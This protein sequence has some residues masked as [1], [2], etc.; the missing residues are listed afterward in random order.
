MFTEGVLFDGKQAYSWL[1]NSLNTETQPVSI[2]SAYLKT[3][4]AVSLVEST[5]N[6]QLRFLARWTLSDLLSGASDLDTYS[7]LR[8]KGM[9]LYVCNSFHGKVYAL[10]SHSILVGSANATRSGFGLIDQANSEVCTLVNS[11]PHNLVLVDSLFASAQLVTDELFEAMSEY[12]ASV[13]KDPKGVQLFWPADIANLLIPKS[14]LSGF[15]LSDCLMTDGEELLFKRS[16]L[17][18]D[19]KNDLSLLSCESS[20]LDSQILA[21]QFKKLKLYQWLIKTLV[22]NDGEMYFGSLTVALHDS[23]MEDPSPYRKTVKVILSN[24][25]NWINLLG[26]ADTCIAI[27]RPNHSQRVRLLNKPTI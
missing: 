10:P 23:M 25:L 12:V 2:C 17:S 16:V 13:P 4:V 8:S 20:G 6:T 7:F 3:P 14:D 26:Q 5:A 18:E 19:A 9:P 27:D 22:D 1:M 21:R 15:L 11:I 24:L